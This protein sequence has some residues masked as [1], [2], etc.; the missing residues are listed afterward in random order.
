MD[1]G[2]DAIASTRALLES[3]AD[4]DKATMALLGNPDKYRATNAQLKAFE[5]VYKTGPFPHALAAAA[6]IKHDFDTAAAAAACQRPVEV[7]TVKGSPAQGG[8][9]TNNNNNNKKEKPSKK[10]AKEVAV[11]EGEEEAPPATISQENVIFSLLTYLQ[12]RLGHY[13]SYCV[14]CNRPHSCWNP[15]GGVVCCEALCVFQLEGSPMEKLVSVRQCPF[16]NCETLDLST[17]GK[18]FMG[19]PLQQVC[20]DYNITSQQLLEMILH[21][22][23]PPEEM[24]KFLNDGLKLVHAK[25]V[26]SCLNPALCAR[27]EHAW[28]KMRENRPDMKIVPRVAYHGT[29]EAGVQGI[30]STGFLISKL[31]QVYMWWLFSLSMQF[32]KKKKKKKGSGDNGW[33]G[34]GI[35]LSQN[36]QTAM[37]YCRGKKML[38]C[39][40]LVKWCFFIVV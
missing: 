10:K 9:G 32:L 24:K 15:D 5:T 7:W 19:L 4:A 27:F 23:L 34:C 35:Y 26:E 14:S 30:S 12:E 36:V 20:K 1:L 8:A 11:E 28:K 18:E 2:F 40:V 29:S 25:K 31:S 37:G 13:S 3:N 6:V 38:V 16:Q 17:A 21:K 39:A 22:Y 33:Y